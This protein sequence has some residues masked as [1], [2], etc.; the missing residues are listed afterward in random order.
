[1]RAAHTSMGAP[2]SGKLRTDHP[3]DPQCPHQMLLIGLAEFDVADWEKNTI[4]RTYNKSSKQIQW[5]WQFVHSISNERRARLLQFV[6]GSCRLPVGGFKDLMGSNGPQRF[7]IEK[8]TDVRLLPRS[9]T[10]FN[11]IDL[12]AYKTKEDLR[13]KLLLAIEETE[14]FGLE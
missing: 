8:L 6:T 3:R 9:H 7:C 2:T 14:G 1:V 10:C 11:R 4:Y 13:E 5:F 12:P